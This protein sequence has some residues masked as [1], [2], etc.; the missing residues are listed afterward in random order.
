MKQGDLLDATG[1]KIGDVKRL[2]DGKVRVCIASAIKVG[3]EYETCLR[4]TVPN[5][6]WMTNAVRKADREGSIL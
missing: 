4:W 3:D 6:K 1:Y 5:C 2:S